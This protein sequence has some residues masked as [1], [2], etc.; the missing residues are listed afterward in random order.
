M[1]VTPPPSVPPAPPVPLPRRRLRSRPSIPVA[2]AHAGVAALCIGIH[3]YQGVT[4]TGQLRP[5]SK[6]AHDSGSLGT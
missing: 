6:P 2:H 3:V 1:G 5:T 4:P